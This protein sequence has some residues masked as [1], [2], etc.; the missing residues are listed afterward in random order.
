VDTTPRPSQLIRTIHQSHP[1]TTA[2]YPKYRMRT[3]NR[4]R[5]T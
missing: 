4:S 3:T 2:Q 5:T 1:T